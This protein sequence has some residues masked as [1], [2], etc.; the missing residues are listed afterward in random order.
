MASGG[1]KLWE[2]NKELQGCV[3]CIQAKSEIY[4]YMLGTPNL[5]IEKTAT[6]IHNLYAIQVIEGPKIYR[7]GIS[8]EFIFDICC[9]ISKRT[10][11]INTSISGSLGILLSYSI[12]SEIIV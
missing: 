6:G 9:T 8:F 10:N 12:K 1:L 5:F 2:R 11:S 7:K 4:V 3:A